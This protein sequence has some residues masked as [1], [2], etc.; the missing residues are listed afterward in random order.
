MENRLDKNLA[1]KPLIN[2]IIISATGED[3]KKSSESLIGGV[4]EW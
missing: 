1:L 3:A 4:A 2:G